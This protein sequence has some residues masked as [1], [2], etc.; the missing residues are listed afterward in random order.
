MCSSLKAALLS[1]IIVQAMSSVREGPDPG[2]IASA[3]KNLAERYYH[4]GRMQLH[5]VG[6]FAK[7]APPP[8]DPPFV[9]RLWRV[10]PLPVRQELHPFSRRVWRRYHKLRKRLRR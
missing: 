6:E 1:G 5:G 10:L 3:D 8:P 7:K 4:P 2:R 9:V